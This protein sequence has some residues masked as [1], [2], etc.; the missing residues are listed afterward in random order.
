MSYQVIEVI[1]K[2]QKNIILYKKVNQI[3]I[4]LFKYRVEIKREKIY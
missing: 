2:K 3:N 1:K 4:Q